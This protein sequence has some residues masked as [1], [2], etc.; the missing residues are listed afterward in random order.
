MLKWD[1]L[2][3]PWLVRDKLVHDK[4]GDFKI[5]MVLALPEVL[6]NFCPT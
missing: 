6:P 2:E 4:P 1:N 3:G 5:F